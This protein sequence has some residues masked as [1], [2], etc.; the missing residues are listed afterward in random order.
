MVN[1]WLRR[2]LA[3]PTWKLASG[4]W[5]LRGASARVEQIPILRYIVVGAGSATERGAGVVAARAKKRQN[6][7]NHMEHSQ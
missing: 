7:P 4:P 1:A 3:K 5:L 6:E 2:P